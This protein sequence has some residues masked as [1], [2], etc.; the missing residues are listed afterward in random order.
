[1]TTRRSHL[2]E[3]AAQGDARARVALELTRRRLHFASTVQLGITLLDRVVDAAR[4]HRRILE[5]DS[6]PE[7]LDDV[8]RKLAKE[9]GVK[10]A[11]SSSARTDAEL[12][13]L[14]GIDETRR[15][16]LEAADVLN[17]RIL[18]GFRRL[19]ARD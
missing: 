3:L 7:R 5:L 16:W 8:H 4:E 9:S 18:A 1:M 19:I 10:V 14:L 2:D 13:F 6:Q 11:I 15:G 12:G 17:T